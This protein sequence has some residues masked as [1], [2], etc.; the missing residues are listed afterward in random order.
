MSV[1]DLVQEAYDMGFRNKSKIAELLGVSRKSIT[2]AVQAGRIEYYEPFDED[3]G[4]NDSHLINSEDD[5]RDEVNKLISECF[6]TDVVSLDVIAEESSFD[7]YIQK[8]YGDVKSAISKEGGKLFLSCISLTCSKCSRPKLLTKYKTKRGTRLGIS[9]VC[10]DCL[11]EG[12]KNNP[13]RKEWVHKRRAIKKNLPSISYQINEYCVFTDTSIIAHDHFIPLDTGHGGTYLGNMIPLCH[14]LN[15]KKL[16]KNPFTWFETNRQRFKL[17]QF[18]FDAVVANLAEQNG[19]IPGEYRR[20][21]DWCYDNK[22]SLDEIIAD[23][24]RYGYVVTSVE[25]WRDATGTPLPLRIV[26]DIPTESVR[27]VS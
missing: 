17:D 5:I 11:Y 6:Y 14:I 9:R 25:L 24:Q 8:I 16:Y 2:R 20:Y 3:W 15:N 10:N 12:Y 22:R 23:N 1:T 21:V 27:I 7:K 13:K 4:I 19:L 26:T 18:R